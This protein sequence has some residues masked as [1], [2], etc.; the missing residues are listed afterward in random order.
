M[1]R[2]LAVL[3]LAATALTAQT[4]APPP[5]TIDTIMAGAQFSGYEPRDLRWSPDGRQ[6]Y[7]RWKDH[8]VSIEKDFDT[9]VVGRDGNGLR[10]LSES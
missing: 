1:K 4:P 9:Y 7:F 2:R 10:K 8:S 3:V 5:L 6:L